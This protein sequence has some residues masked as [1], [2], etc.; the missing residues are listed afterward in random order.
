[1]KIDY[2]LGLDAAKQKV[3]V[4]LRGR[5][6]ERFLLEKD[7]P[8]S[9][10]GRRELLA[11]LGRHLPPEAALLVL[12]EATGV[13][14][15]H[16]AAALSKA[17][18]AVAVINPLMARRLYRVKNSLR[19]NKTDPIDARQLCA[20]AARE[21]AELFAKYRFALAPERC[22]LQR[23]ESVRQ[24][25]RH[26]LTNL[27]K[28]YGSLLDL[29]FPELGELLEI[30]G[31]GIRALLQKAPTP[32]AIARLR[33]A[34]LEKD[35]KLRPKA[36]A[37]KA[38]A[39]DSIADPELAAASAPALVALLQSMAELEAR[40]RALDRQIEQ[41][42]L[43]A[44]DPA[45][46]QLIQTLP[47]FG[48]ITAAKLIA[49][50]PEEVLQ[51]GSNRTAAT[52]LQAFM[53]ND[54]RLKESGQFKG[55]VKMTKRGVEPLRTAFFQ[56]AFSASQHDPELKAYYQRKRAQGKE[57]KVALSHLMRILTRRLVAVLR[58]QQPYRPMELVLLKNAA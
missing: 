58:S 39:A 44:A 33:R 43:Q 55:K 35:W 37:L 57:H 11:L 30:D 21:G 46:H 34:T 41:L 16:W 36:R 20:L 5:A 49:Y 53:G 7:L 50:L 13:L 29:I 27:K 1:M 51:A 23:L 48:P 19:E 3:R 32:Q 8:V 26:A 17:G 54:P 14:H 15:L 38:L 40:L 25:C 47:G 24:S 9:A 28:T 4:A 18:H 6:T 42:A 45:R 31:V 56:A 10:A 2:Y 12:I 52:R 22:A